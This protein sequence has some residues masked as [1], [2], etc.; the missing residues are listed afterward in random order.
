MSKD[1]QHILVLLDEAMKAGARQ[2]KACEILGVSERVIQRWRLAEEGG[3]DARKG[4]KLPNNKLSKAEE[5]EI[6]QVVND[7]E[8]RE[9][10]PR[11]IVPKLADRGIYLASESTIYRLL[12]RS[13]M[14]KPRSPK[15]F[16]RRKK[17]VEKKATLP[18]QVWS[19][20]ITFLPGPTKGTFYY[21]YAIIDIFS[22][23]IVGWDVHLCQAQ[24]L[25]ALLIDQTCAQEGIMRE[26]LI[27]HSDNGG[28]MKGWVMLEKL[29]SLGVSASFSRPRV[30]DDNPFSESL[31]STLK[32][33]HWYPKRGFRSIE[34]AHQWAAIFVHWY[35]HIHLHSEIGYVTP[36]QRHE[37]EDIEVLEQRR[38]LYEE[39][40]VKNPQRWSGKSRSWIR[41]ETVILNPDRALERKPLSSFSTFDENPV[42]HLDPSFILAA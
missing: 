14:M 1:R 9:L 3:V 26:Q 36:N 33:R 30:S 31:F 22:R 38:A 23:K 20:D 18:C 40:R 37:G 17:P 13:E 15:S 41:P 6:L 12:H 8:F 4:P 5:K 19:W 24:E 29:R 32:S 16:H 21:L 11:Q 27:L 39:A 10:S 25:S 28:P 42:S 35:N 2:S 7:L 34:E